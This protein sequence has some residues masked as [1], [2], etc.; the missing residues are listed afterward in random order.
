MIS[1][2]VVNLKIVSIDLFI[3]F[4][5]LESPKMWWI[6]DFVGFSTVEPTKR[7][8]IFMTI[9]FLPLPIYSAFHKAAVQPAAV[10]NGVWRA[11]CMV[12]SFDTLGIIPVKTSG[13]AVNREAGSF[14]NSAVNQIDVS[15]KNLD[16]RQPCVF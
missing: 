1:Y 16:W 9:V 8:F 13:T 15:G 12:A 5:K 10:Q 2:K 4:Y 3:Y 14:V 7:N 11:F 6:E